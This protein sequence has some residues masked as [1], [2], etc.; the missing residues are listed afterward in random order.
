MKKHEKSQFVAK[1]SVYFGF[2]VVEWVASIFSLSFLLPYMV[3]FFEKWRIE[4]S[5]IDGHA[6]HFLGKL[7]QAYVIYAVYLV[8]FAGFSAVGNIV[9]YYLNLL[10][11]SELAFWVFNGISLLLSTI[12]L[13][14]QYRRWV[15]RK[16]SFDGT[17]APTIIK[18]ATFDKFKIYLKAW[19]ITF[20]SL[21]LASPHAHE[22]KMKYFA[23]LTKI[24]D[25]PL[26]FVGTKEEMYHFWWGVLALCFVTL[27]LYI[28]IL[29]YKIYK[30][31]VEGLSLAA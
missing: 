26:R 22:L 6:L 15:R 27:G 1:K 23:S 9:L 18:P 5:F 10:L 14:G 31:R 4:N 28:P 20:F 7:W 12:L 2:E 29:H 13:Q 16:L 3:Y 11:P 19:L 17:L 25:L 21:K 8:F 30:W 24:N